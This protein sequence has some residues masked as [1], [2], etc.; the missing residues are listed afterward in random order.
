MTDT[1]SLRCH[2]PRRRIPKRS[3]RRHRRQ[4]KENIAAIS[5][6]TESVLANLHE[7]S[8][9]TEPT[10][11]PEAAGFP[12]PGAP[13][14]R[15]FRGLPLDYSS[16]VSYCLFEEVYRA[17]GHVSRV[18]TPER[19]MSQDSTFGPEEARWTAKVTYDAVPRGG[20]CSARGEEPEE[21]FVVTY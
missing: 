8:A 7:L 1:K 19:D 21:T 16:A 12:V 18:E 10:Q 5:Y 9:S 2:R 15:R 4:R 13:R 17:L 20:I 11:S 14:K 3:D 6:R